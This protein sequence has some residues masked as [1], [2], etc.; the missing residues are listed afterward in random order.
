MTEGTI[1]RPA[2]IQ[3]AGGLRVPARG[4]MPHLFAVLMSIA[5]TELLLLVLVPWLFVHG[6]DSL[7]VSSER[8]SYL[9]L[10][11]LSGLVFGTLGGV[12]AE[13]RGDSP[14]WALA[15]QTG[16]LAAPIFAATNMVENQPFMARVLVAALGTAGAI[17]A[18][19]PS[20]GSAAWTAG[21]VTHALARMCH[22]IGNIWLGISWLVLLTASIFW[23]SWVETIYGHKAAMATIYASG[24]IGFIFFAFLLSLVAAT[25]RKYPWR[26]DQTGWIVVHIALVLIIVGSLMSFWGKREG[27][28]MLAEGE[29]SSHFQAE[30]QTRFILEEAR[31]VGE[32]TVWRKVEEVICRFDTNPANM[33]P[34]EHVRFKVAGEDAFDITVARWFADADRSEVATDD[35]KEPRIAVRGKIDMPGGMDGPFLLSEGGEERGDPTLLMMGMRRLPDA[36]AGEQLRAA[37][38]GQGTLEVLDASGAVLLSHPVT[39]GDYNAEKGNRPLTIDAEIPGTGVRLKGKAMYAN[40]QLLGAQ[41]SRKPMDASPNDPR[42]PAA[43]FSLE[44]PKGSDPRWAFTWYPEI[45][46]PAPE[47]NVYSEFTVRWR[48]FPVPRGTLWFL[49]GEGVESFWAYQSR[50]SG[51]RHGQV[52]PGTALELGIPLQVTPQQIFTHLRETEKWD[53]KGFSP[54]QSVAQLNVNVDGMNSEAWLPL[55]GSIPLE[56]AG[57]RFRLRW[58]RTQLPL[59][60]QLM[61]HDF[62]RDYYPGSTQEST[63][64]SYLRLRDHDQFKD[65]AD[66][67]IDMNHPLRLNGWRLFQARYSTEGGEST[68]LQ[69]NRDPGLFVIYPACAILVLGMVLVFFQKPFLR[70]IG[71]KLAQRTPLTRFGG[72][73][74]AIALVTAATLPGVL[75]IGFL[76]SGPGKGVGALLVALGLV[77]ETWLVSSVLT[78]RVERAAK[79]AA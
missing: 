76:P 59:P 42:N 20:K 19:L 46:A 65:G 17:G 68:I 31:T 53:F 30:D 10:S 8:L 78:A 71:R 29:S 12:F 40:W 72:A 28:L 73:L 55:G 62:R 14:W 48:W 9:G 32:K 23:G 70:A 35:G 49:G 64:E 67:K 33:E 61:L 5:A 4:E 21:R 75:V 3:R 27:E 54:M 26:V 7:W 1:Q 79:E 2:A 47:R 22:A 16:V 24:W 56:R 11:V 34:G 77:L 38:P 25:L 57:E 37:A 50:S 41:G 39:S 69:V 52:V 74:L 43:A 44:G 18:S 63:F 36:L 15:G 45:L 60:F 66:I 51:L 6:T 13:R 58:Q